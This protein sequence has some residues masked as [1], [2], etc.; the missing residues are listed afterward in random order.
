M[1][2]HPGLPQDPNAGGAPPQGAAPPPQEP[3]AAA[4]GQNQLQ[5]AEAQGGEDLL[6]PI[7]QMSDMIVQMAG[8][9]QLAAIL[10]QGLEQ[11]MTEAQGA[12]G[13]PP[14]EA[15]P[16]PVQGGEGFGPQG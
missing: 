6:Q 4:P 10:Q 2:G 9:E 5:P 11:L 3:A 14:V 8:P 15:V 16:Q 13:Q 7:Q 12:Q 1:P